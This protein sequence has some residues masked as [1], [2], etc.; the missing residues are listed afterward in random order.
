MRAR[1]VMVHFVDER[2]PVAD[3]PDVVC[4]IIGRCE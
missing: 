1:S 3:V 2:Q 4:A